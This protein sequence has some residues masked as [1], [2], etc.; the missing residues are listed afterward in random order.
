MFNVKRREKPFNTFKQ[1][2][3]SEAAAARKD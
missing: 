2:G 1:L 3:I